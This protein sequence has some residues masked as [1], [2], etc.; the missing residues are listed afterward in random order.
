MG[1]REVELGAAYKAR[2]DASASPSTQ[3]PPWNR[4]RSGRGPGGSS[5]GTMKNA[6]MGWPSTSLYSVRN[7]LNLSRTRRAL[8]CCEAGSMVYRSILAANASVVLASYEP[9][10]ESR[11]VRYEKR[12]G[13]EKRKEGGSPFL[14]RCS[15]RNCRSHRTWLIL[16][17]L[18]EGTQDRDRTL[19]LTTPHGIAV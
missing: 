19:P 16:R 1:R 18:P 4:T 15:A 17:D 5:S 9:M 14:G 2:I 6:W 10:P 12:K 8:G 11:F 7:A 13:V 3:P